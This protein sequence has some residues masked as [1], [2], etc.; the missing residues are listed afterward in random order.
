MTSNFRRDFFFSWCGGVMNPSL[1]SA[2]AI[3]CLP[4]VLVG[5]LLTV[6]AVTGPLSGYRGAKPAK[7]DEPK[8]SRRTTTEPVTMEVRFT[9]N[10]TLRLT[11][12]DEPLAVYTAY[13]RVLVPITDI[14]RIYFATRLSDEDAKRI[15]AAMAN[16]SNPQFRLREA[17]TAELLKLGVKAYPALLRAAKADDAEVVRRAEDLLAKVRDT[18]SERQLVI[19]EHDVIYTADSKITGQI[20]G[21]ALKASSLQFGDVELKLMDMRSLRSLAVATEAR[22][23]NAALDPGDLTKLQDKIGKT[24]SFKVTGSVTGTIW[25][26][27]VYTS[28]SPLAVVAVHAGLVKPGQTRVIRVTIVAPPAAFNGST[29][30]G[31][32]SSPYGPFSGAYRISK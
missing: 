30:N 29:Q 3:K 13:G 11:L 5:S 15:E 23:K 24:F 4:L 25:G 16:L 2:L 32:T 18:V 26:S 22:A 9:D 28:D 6:L 10:G 12:R 20:A 14:H 31:V 19:R 17:A 7:E 1:R 27:G 21:S 8:E